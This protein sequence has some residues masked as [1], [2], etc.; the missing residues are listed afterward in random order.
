METTTIIICVILWYLF[1]SVG[2]SILIY[3]TEGEYTLGDLLILFSA[4]GVGGFV[5]FVFLL[6]DTVTEEDIVLFK[7]KIK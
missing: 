1:G 6:I 4:G 3:Y 7:K 5:F 2:S